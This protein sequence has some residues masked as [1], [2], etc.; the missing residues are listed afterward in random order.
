MWVIT[1]SFWLIKKYNYFFYA[2]HSISLSIQILLQ[3]GFYLILRSLTRIQTYGFV[4]SVWHRRDS[5]VAFHLQKA[6]NKIEFN[7][8][9][10]TEGLEVN[11]SAGSVV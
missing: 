6:S 4:S 7:H 2:V 9:R 1:F 5:P 11:L 10:Q 3:Q 8:R